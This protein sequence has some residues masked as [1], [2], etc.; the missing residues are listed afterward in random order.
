MGMPKMEKDF[1]YALPKTVYVR[2]VDKS[3]LPA[4]L[5]EATADIPMP[6]SLHAPNGDR[7]AI[8]KDRDLAFLVARQNDFNAVY[9]N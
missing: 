6:Y 4:D 7:L 3:T 9:V 8:V 5:Q 2:A 1:A